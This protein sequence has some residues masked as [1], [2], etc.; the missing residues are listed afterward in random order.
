M[1][2]VTCHHHRY[3]ILCYCN[4][5]RLIKDTR[6][7]LLCGFYTLVVQTLVGCAVGHMW[8]CQAVQESPDHKASVGS[9]NALVPCGGIK[10]VYS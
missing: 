5:L 4:Q 6:P 2:P 10:P 8:T 1:R 9:V 7:A 3:Y